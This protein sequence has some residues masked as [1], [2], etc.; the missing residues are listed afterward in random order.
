MKEKYKFLFCFIMVFQLMFIKNMDYFV[1]NDIFID[2]VKWISFYLF[3]L[4]MFVSEYMFM[5]LKNVWN[6][7]CIENSKLF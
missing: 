4:Q 1:K 6:V 7:E 5:V 2:V 3:W